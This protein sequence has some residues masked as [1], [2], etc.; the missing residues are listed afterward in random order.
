LYQKIEGMGGLT[1]KSNVRL[2]RPGCW[3]NKVCQKVHQ[4][5]G[6]CSVALVWRPDRHSDSFLLGFMLENMWLGT[7]GAVAVTFV[8][9]YATFRY[10]GLQKYRQLINSSLML[11]YRKNSFII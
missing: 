2:L 9:F 11:C 3:N 1:R 8:I 10:T 7:M 4:G 5:K 6:G